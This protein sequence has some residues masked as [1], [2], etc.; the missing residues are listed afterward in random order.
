[1]LW[2]KFKAGK[3]ASSSK[4]KIT[5]LDDDSNDDDEVYMPDGM[6]GGGSMYGLEDDLDGYDDYRTQVYD[7]TPQEQAFCDQYDIRL[8]SRGKPELLVLL[9][10]DGIM[11]QNVQ[12]TKPVHYDKYYSLTL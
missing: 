9:C 7:L 11:P 4:S 10:K 5:S 3:V 12:F 6:A 8:N 2:E 1:M